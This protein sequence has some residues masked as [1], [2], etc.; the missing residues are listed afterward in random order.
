[1]TRGFY[2]CHLFVFIAVKTSRLQQDCPVSIY[3]YAENN[4]DWAWKH[5]SSSI[6]RT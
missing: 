5:E 2:D 3:L 4:I 6:Y 1:V